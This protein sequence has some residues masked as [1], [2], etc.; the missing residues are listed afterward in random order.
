MPLTP[1]ALCAGWLLADFVIISLARFRSANWPHF[2]HNTELTEICESWAVVP[3]L[4]EK[5]TKPRT[6]L[7]CLQEDLVE[8]KRSMAFD[9]RDLS[10]MQ[11]FVQGISRGSCGDYRC[12]LVVSRSKVAK[13]PGKRREMTNFWQNTR[14]F[15]MAAGWARAIHSSRRLTMALLNHLK[16]CSR[17]IE[18]VSAHILGTETTA[19]LKKSKR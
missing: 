12:N 17:T 7:R 16:C 11:L 13:L 1:L 15:T 19:R 5:P 9:T 4:I 10:G 8:A 3:L 18:E 2:G 14:S 6:A